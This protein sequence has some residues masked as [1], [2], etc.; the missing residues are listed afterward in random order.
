MKKNVQPRCPIRGCP[1]RFSS[2]ENRLCPGHEHDRKDR[3]KLSPY[4][5]PGWVKSQVRY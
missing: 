5:V 3:S 4:P 2:G 1:V